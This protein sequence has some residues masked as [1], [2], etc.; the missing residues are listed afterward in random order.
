MKNLIY[1]IIRIVG[2]VLA[3]FNLLMFYAIDVVSSLTSLTSI[4]SLTS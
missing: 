2:T 1:K 4:T 3:F